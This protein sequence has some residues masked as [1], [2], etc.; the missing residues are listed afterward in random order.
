MDKK[1]T[2][3]REAIPLKIE[4]NYSSQS[5]PANTWVIETLLTSLLVY[6]GHIVSS[7]FLVS[8]DIEICGYRLAHSQ[9]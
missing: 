6:S 1:N 3:C 2:D 4:I 7:K 9:T 5:T 8:Y